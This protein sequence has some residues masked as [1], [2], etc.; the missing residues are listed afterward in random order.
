[1][2]GPMYSADHVDRQL[3]ALQELARQLHAKVEPASSIVPPTA[4]VF[5]GAGPSRAANLPLAPELRN[6]LYNSFVAR[7][8]PDARIH[9]LLDDELDGRSIQGISLF[10]FVAVISKF[11]YGRQV[12]KDT[13]E[14]RLSDPSHRPL[15]YELLAHLAKHRYVD[16]FIV[17]NFDRLLDQVL[18]DELPDRAHVVASPQ[19]IPRSESRTGQECFVVHPFGIL[20]E[21]SYSLTPSDV[22]RFGADP[23]RAFVEEKL[24][25]SVAAK[26]SQSLLLLLV[27][28]RAEEP[29]FVRFLRAQQDRWKRLYGQQRQID[30]F[31]IDPDTTVGQMFTNLRD[32]GIVSSAHHIALGADDAFE[33]L[34]DLLDREWKSSGHPVWIP[35]A[36]HR[37]VSK[38]FSHSQLLSRK[39]RFKIE[40]LLQGLKSRGFVHLEA[41]GHIPRIRNYGSHISADTI[42]ELLQERVLTRDC[43]LAPSRGRENYVPNFMIEDRDRV[44]RVFIDL[45]RERGVRAIEEWRVVE[46]GA[47]VHAEHKQLE[48]CEFLVREIEEIQRAPEIEIVRDVAPEV[49]WILGAEG[50]PLSTIDELTR[51]TRSML[52]AALKGSAQGV[53]KLYGIWSTGEWLFHEGGWAHDLGG[54][55]LGRSD[56][57]LRVIIT[58]AGGVG[59]DR[60]RRRNAVCRRL[61]SAERAKVQLRWLNWWELNRILTL[62]QDANGECRAVY[63]RRRLSRPLVSPYLIESGAEHA[64]KYLQELWDV[65]WSRAAPVT[66]QDVTEEQ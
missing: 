17:L 4:L 1:M 21:G 54:Q 10:E 40:L 44:I 18:S 22:A 47:G 23:I 46:D 33:L 61:L 37:I 11:A 34:F 45:S 6:M 8:A 51:M 62:V 2:N 39:E 36:R 43:W 25:G 57:E 12:I 16:H 58:R 9:A 19:D 63:M 30:M 65:Y 29:A 55:L 20:G 64:L 52:D 15:S 13:I 26:R 60:S 41:F 56:V 49:P 32:E 48:P 59:G 28:Y 27:G 42:R 53:T 7:D 38:L 14:E 31:V 5:V 3:G 35:V 50:K 66:V 24:L